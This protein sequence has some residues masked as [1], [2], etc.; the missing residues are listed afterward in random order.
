[1]QFNRMVC[2]LCECAQETPPPYPIM[3]DLFDQIDSEQDA[4]LDQKEWN[5]AFSVVETDDTREMKGHSSMVKSLAG[6]EDSR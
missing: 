2:R 3:K 1:M 5:K 6:W 4:V